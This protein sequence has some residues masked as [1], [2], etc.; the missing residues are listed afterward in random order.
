MKKIFNIC[1]L[2]ILLWLLYN[3]HW[4]DVGNL[5]PLLDALSNVFLGFNLLIS[6]YCTFKVLTHYPINYFFKSMNVLLVMFIVY[7]LISI[8]FGSDIK[9]IDKGAYLIGALR[10][11]LPIYTCFLFTKL[12]YITEE[13]IRIWVWIFLAESILI[14]FSFRVVLDVGG[15]YDLRTNNRGYLFATL[16]P[17]IY[18]F[19][20]KTLLQYL[21][22]LVLLFFSVQSIKRGAILIV[23]LGTIY[24]FWYKLSNVK[25]SRKILVLSALVLFVWIGSTFIE[26]LYNES[27][28]FQDR[29]EATRQG[30]TSRRDVIAKGL[31]DKYTNADAFHMLFGFGADGT[32]RTGVYAHND[33]LEMLFN[34]GPMGLL[35]FF[36]FWLN[37]FL[38]WRRQAAK[39]SEMAF[40][41]GILFIC[42]F[43]K[44]FFSMW[45]S[46]ANI[47]VTLPLG[48]CLA[49]IFVAK[50]QVAKMGLISKN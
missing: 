31:M 38:L 11:F 42:N 35:V 9:G 50:R 49:N 17:F 40:L 45:Y 20:N 3:F 23:S 47:F 1:N 22:L 39:N 43:P 26:G 33:W 6:A 13:S 21:L 30:D 10:T 14:Y 25:T 5:F 48:Y 41:I 36:F 46:A 32:V 4:N 44:T 34:Q 12:G 16:L 29:V 2:Y 24:L 7:G 28:V 27:T 37:W 15:T 8:A 18:F 19:R